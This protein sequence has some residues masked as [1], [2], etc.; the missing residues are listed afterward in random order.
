MKP[1]F[2]RSAARNPR[3]RAKRFTSSFFTVK[4]GDKEELVA[5]TIPV[6]GAYSKT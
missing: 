1:S 6:L 5:L 3:S 4:R 2:S